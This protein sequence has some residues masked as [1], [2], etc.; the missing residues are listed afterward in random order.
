MAMYSAISRKPASNS[1]AMTG[2]ITLNG[3]LLAI[4]GLNEK[5]LAAKR[6]KINTVLIPKENEIDLSEIS[7]K[8]KD[9]I[10]I[11]AIEKVEE[12]IPYVIPAVKKRSSAKK[13][14]KKTSSKK[15]KN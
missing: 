5:L 4:G 9:G 6:N 12:A 13:S 15:Q 10:K 1:V 7:E 11:V 8:V 3:S 2:E 14:K